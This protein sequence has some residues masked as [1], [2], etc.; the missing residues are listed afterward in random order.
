MSTF[1]DR[2]WLCRCRGA[3]RAPQTIVDASDVSEE[4]GKKKIMEGG[5]PIE[6]P[7]RSDGEIL[8]EIAV[9]WGPSARQASLGFASV[10]EWSKALH[11]SRSRFDGVGSNPTGCIFL[12]FMPP[13]TLPVEKR[14]AKE[15]REGSGT[16]GGV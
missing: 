10:A 8:Q 6:G 15:G 2:V 4:V 9:P 7:G 1:H 3:S 16:Q 14:V 13:A 5:R 11:S 12:F